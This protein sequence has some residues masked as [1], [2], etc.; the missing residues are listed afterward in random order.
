MATDRTPRS[1]IKGMLRQM[2]LRSRER[3]ACLRRDKYTCQNEE[4]IGVYKRMAVHHIDHNRNNNDP[5]NL[6]TLCNPCNAREES[7]KRNYR[8]Y[9]TQLMQR[10]HPEYYL[11]RQDSYQQVEV[12]G[13]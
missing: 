3:N 4:C 8:L 11:V 1:L 6:I 7:K 5:I 13:G 9:Y 10:L 2:F 12:S